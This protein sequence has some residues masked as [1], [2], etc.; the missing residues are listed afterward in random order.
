MAEE[1]AAGRPWRILV[2]TPFPPRLDGRHGGSRALAEFVAGLARENRVALIAL[3]AD[4]ELS[5]DEIL[6]GK[7]DLVEEVRIP[8]VGKSFAARLGNWIRLRVS[9][10]RGTPTWAAE[11]A[12]VDFSDRLGELA[13]TW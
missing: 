13:H 9:L 12:T 10:L 7:C 11:R 8:P 2:A 5:V 3:R 6:A 4:G 1:D